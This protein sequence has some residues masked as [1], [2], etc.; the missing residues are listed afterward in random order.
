MF[1]YTG[2]ICYIEELNDLNEKILFNFIKENANEY[3]HY[4]CGDFIPDTEIEFSKLLNNYFSK[5]RVYQ[6]L[7]FD[8]KNNIIGTF[9]FY[10]YNNKPSSINISCFFSKE[11]RG[12]FIVSEALISAINFA[13]NVIKIEKLCFSIY[14]ENIHML[15]IANKIEAT[16]IRIRK[17]LINNNRLIQTFFINKENVKKIIK[18]KYYEK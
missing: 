3:K 6:F 12:K 8:K 17:S 14:N 5:G 1:I 18:R 16:K 7:I 2:D 13:F 15:S 11:V 9:F 10:C 4:L